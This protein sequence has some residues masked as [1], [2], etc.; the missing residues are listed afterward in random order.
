[1]TIEPVTSLADLEF[2]AKADKHYEQLA[3][4]GCKSIMYGTCRIRTYKNAIK[5]LHEIAVANR[6]YADSCQFIMK[7]V[8]SNCHRIVPIVPQP[9]VCEVVKKLKAKNVRKKSIRK[10]VRRRKSV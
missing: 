5:K 8:N 2:K 6:G 1:M 9:P 7:H 4:L 3:V 10:I